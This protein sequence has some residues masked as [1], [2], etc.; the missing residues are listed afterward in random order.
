MFQR[1]ENEYLSRNRCVEMPRTALHTH[2]Q[3]A[4]E[5]QRRPV[6]RAGT[7]MAF[8]AMALSG[9]FWPVFCSAGSFGGMFS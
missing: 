1:Q 8:L 5:R 6:P 2:G 4:Q 9:R 3:G 7:G